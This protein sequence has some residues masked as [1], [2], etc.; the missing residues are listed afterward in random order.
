VIPVLYP[1]NETAF[2]TNGLGGLPDAISCVVTEQRNTQGGYYLEMDY[3]IDGLHFDLLAPERIIY[4]A[5]SMGNT[6]QPFRI[7]RITRP[8]N[9]IVHIEAPHVSSELQKIVTYGSFPVYTVYGGFD[10][11]KEIATG[12]GQLVPF[13]MTS[14]IDLFTVQRIEF[15]H[16]ASFSDV[17]LGAEGSF[18]DKIGGEFEWD[19]WHVILHKQRGVDTGLEIRYGVNMSDLNAETDAAEL[20]TAVIPFWKGNVNDTETV[21]IGSMCTASNASAFAYV[22][23][24]PLDVTQEF[25]QMEQGQ[26]PTAAQVTAKGQAF[27]DST[28]QSELS[29][30]INVKYTPITTGIGERRI[31]LCDTVRV[32]HPDLNL[33]STAKVVETKYNTL[34]EQYDELTIGSIRKS[35]VDTIADIIKK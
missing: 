22:R 25:Q 33:S 14:D 16:P 11:F 21:V 28:S 4:A 1:A 26:Q 35:I 32:V 15:P 24:V 12:L 19:G 2:T 7:S 8:I 34:V 3:P 29:M 27:I 18:L 9:G 23:C 20:V 5:P 31:N 10:T 30:S 17:L 6:P 13:Y